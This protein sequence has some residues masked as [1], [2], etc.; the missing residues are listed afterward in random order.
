MALTK[1]PASITYLLDDVEQEIFFH[2]VE[3]EDHQASA[4]VTKYPVQTGYHISNH[5]IRQNRVVSLVG[6]ITNVQMFGAAGYHDYGSDA[7]SLVAEA[8]TA[9]V[10]NGVECTVTTNLGIYENVV[11]T[12]YRTKQGAGMMD[13]AKFEMSGEEVIKITSTNKAAPAPISFVGVEDANRIAVQDYLAEHGFSTHNCDELLQGSF[14]IGDDFVIDDVDSQ[15]NSVQTT[16]EFLYQDPTTLEPTYRIVV[17]ESAAKA[18]TAETA[19]AAT[20]PCASADTKGGFSQITDKLV[21]DLFEYAEETA[22]EYVD[23]ALGKLAKAARGY[24]YDTVTF[25]SEA[26]SA[27]MNAGISSVIKG[28]TGNVIGDYVPGESLPTATQIIDGIFNSGG[29]DTPTRTVPQTVTLTQIKC[30]CV[31][32][33]S[34]DIDVGA[35]PSIFDI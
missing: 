21:D 1:T 17:S 33:T 15:G 9:L 34:E 32:D 26:G 10:Q 27:I 7:S 12:R 22:L 31:E 29:T 25:G 13:S 35:I 18:Y 23:T 5:S 30:A 11:F 2:A 28:A 8:L 20:D 16:Y 14:N 6:H 4:T 3:T 24:Y 19:L